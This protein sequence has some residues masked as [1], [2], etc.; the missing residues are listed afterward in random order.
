MSPGNE[1]WLKRRVRVFAGFDKAREHGPMAEGVVVGY[2][3]APTITVRSDD[4][5]QSDWQ[6]TLPIDVLE[7]DAE[8]P[9]RPDLHEMV[10]RIARWLHQNFDTEGLAWATEGDPG[11]EHYRKL[12][13]AMISQLTGVFD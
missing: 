7:E 2:A 8:I 3:P 9:D 12:A 4:G 6:I 1:S 5:R 10:E 11:R 13:R